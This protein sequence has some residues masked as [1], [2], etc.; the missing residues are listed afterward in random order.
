MVDTA[1][2]V[3]VAEAGR[4]PPG[5]VPPCRSEPPA[6]SAGTGKAVPV[7]QRERRPPLQ[8]RVQASRVFPLWVQDSKKGFWM[9]TL[10]RV[11]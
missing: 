3:L 7:S 1:A 2:P 10:C 5:T 8:K 6:A 4:G 11:A 9:C